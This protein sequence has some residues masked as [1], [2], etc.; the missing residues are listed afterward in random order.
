MPVDDQ[1]DRSGAVEGT[2]PQGHQPRPEALEAGL[3][4]LEAMLPPEATAPAFEAGHRV[5]T[6][7][8]ANTR[9]PSARSTMACAT[10]ARIS[11]NCSGYSCRK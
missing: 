9:A 4:A 7:S 10:G 2:P 8:E 1:P 6:S 3:A 11:S 5:T